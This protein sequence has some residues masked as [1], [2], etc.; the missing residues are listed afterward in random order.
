MLTLWHSLHRYGSVYIVSITI[1]PRWSESGTIL[2]YV[3]IYT[4][5]FICLDS[6]AFDVRSVS[7]TSNHAVRRSASPPSPRQKITVTSGGWR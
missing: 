5:F 6:V 7:A 1:R 4:S 3:Y 2:F